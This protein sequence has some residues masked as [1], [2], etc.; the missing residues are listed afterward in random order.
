MHDFKE[1]AV[2]FM[3]VLQ[4]QNGQA[5][6]DMGCSNIPRYIS[7]RQRFGEVPNFR[8]VVSY[9]REKVCVLVYFP[10]PIYEIGSNKQGI[11]LKDAK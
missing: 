8:G 10:S 6:E 11:C 3:S 4:A 7:G 9:I 1:D 2:M 5:T